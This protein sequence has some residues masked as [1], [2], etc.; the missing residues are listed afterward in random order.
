LTSE[1]EK[2]TCTE[3]IQIET[4]ELKGTWQLGGFSGVYAEIGSS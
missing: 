2:S 3:E 1:A 4:E